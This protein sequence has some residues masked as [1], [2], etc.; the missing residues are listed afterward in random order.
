V[1]KPLELRHKYLSIK[2]KSDDVC[3][4]DGDMQSS[5]GSV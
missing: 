5:T 1:I 4:T 2:T 3:A